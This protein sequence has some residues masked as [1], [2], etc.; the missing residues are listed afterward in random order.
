MN[1]SNLSGAHVVIILI[2]ES[3]I[4]N[5]GKPE[6]FQLLIWNTILSTVMLFATNATEAVKATSELYRRIDKLSVNQLLSKQ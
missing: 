4:P 5:E 6:N 1:T 3:E 2:L